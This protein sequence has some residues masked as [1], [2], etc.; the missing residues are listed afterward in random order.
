MTKNASSSQNRT[1]K[2]FLSLL[3]TS[4]LIVNVNA[5]VS[6]KPS[7]AALFV[8][9]QNRRKIQSNKSLISNNFH[10]HDLNMKTSTVL[11]MGMFDQDDG[12]IA[13]SDKLL[14]CLPYLLPLLDGEF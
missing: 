9:E 8:N 7:S 4:L 2:S 1:M 3:T 14:A 12:E 13:G 10:N 6:R 5:F 11:Q